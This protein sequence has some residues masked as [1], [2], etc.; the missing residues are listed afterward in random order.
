MG[1]S[2]SSP[3]LWAGIGLNLL[4]STAGSRCL[5][6]LENYETQWLSYLTNYNVLIETRGSTDRNV[7]ILIP[8]AGEYNTSGMNITIESRRFTNEASG[9]FRTCIVLSKL[10]HRAQINT[11]ATV[12]RRQVYWD[13]ISGHLFWE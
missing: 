2:A 13:E 9:F 7:H 4:P 12:T 6:R 1:F 5:L 8:R 3:Y 10:P 11:I